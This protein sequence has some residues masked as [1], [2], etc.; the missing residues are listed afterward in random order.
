[1]AEILDRNCAAQG[2]ALYVPA[3]YAPHAPHARVPRRLASPSF[4][5][6]DRGLSKSTKWAC[7]PFIYVK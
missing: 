4:S 5:R 3:P 1:M 2:W 6:M 7:G